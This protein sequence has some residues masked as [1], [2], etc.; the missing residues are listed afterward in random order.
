MGARAAH[1]WLHVFLPGAGWVPFDPTTSILGGTDLNR[2]AYTRTLEQ[3]AP[4]SGNW[5]GSASDDIGMAVKVSV[6]RIDAETAYALERDPTGE[7]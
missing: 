6:R 5:T 4:V 7:P 3:A 2:V 1:A